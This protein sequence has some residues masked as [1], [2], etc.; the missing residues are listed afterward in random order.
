M[1]AKK[2]E[3]MSFEESLSELEQLVKELE[4]GDLPLEQAMK[5]FE[6]GIALAGV[7]QKKL[8]QAEQQIKVLRQAD[9]QTPLTTLGEGESL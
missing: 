4:Q 9:S 5:H 3:N 6:R 1:A 2:P 7:G 8:E